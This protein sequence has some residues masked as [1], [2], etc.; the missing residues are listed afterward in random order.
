MR[1]NMITQQT[2]RTALNAFW[3]MFTASMRLM[4]R[5]EGMGVAINSVDG[6][7]FGALICIQNRTSTALLELLGIDQRA[8]GS[9]PGVRLSDE[10]DRCLCDSASVYPDCSESDGFP[11]EFYEPLLRTIRA[12][13]ITLPWEMEE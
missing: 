9:S 7:G 5:L 6:D 10:I 2:F 8:G 12:A 1:H 4:D 13:G 3:Y 11:E